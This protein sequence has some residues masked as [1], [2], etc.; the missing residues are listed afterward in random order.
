MLTSFGWSLTVHSVSV[1]LRTLLLDGSNVES[2]WTGTIGCT[3][4][5]GSPREL[6]SLLL[7]LSISFTPSS[8]DP[9]C[10][11]TNLSRCCGGRGFLF[12][13]SLPSFCFFLDGLDPSIG[14]LYVSVTSDLCS[15]IW[16]VTSAMGRRAALRAANALT[17]GSA[18]RTKSF[19]GLGARDYLP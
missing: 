15:S 5:S 16:L 6:E 11:L 2:L 7:P 8:M 19:F 17:A 12:L 1:S 14:S 3:R 4:V 9:P 13:G 18:I 10:T